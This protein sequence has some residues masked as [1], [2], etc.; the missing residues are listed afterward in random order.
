MPLFTTPDGRYTVAWQTEGEGDGNSV[1]YDRGRNLEHPW[2]GVPVWDRFSYEASLGE[3]QTPPGPP[4][5]PPPP[6]DLPPPPPTA[7]GGF[8]EPIASAAARPRLSRA[9]MGFI[10]ERGPFMFPAPYNTRG[11]RI[12][13]VSDGT[14]RPVG[15][16]YW[17]N[18]N[19]HAARAELL[20]F[21][22]CDDVLTIFAVD[23][24]SG[25]VEKR[26]TLP[27]QMT[28]ES[29]YFSLT[30]ADVLYT[31]PSNG[32]PF[33]RYHLTTHRQD[34]IA[35]HVKQ[36]HSSADGRVHSFSID[37]GPAYWRDG[38]IK[39]LPLKGEYDE[40]QIDKSGR[41]LLSKESF[42]RDGRTHQDNCIWDLATGRM[43]ILRDEDGALGH[44][45]MGYG[46]MIGEEDQSDPGGVFRVW[47][48]GDDGTVSDG[49]MVYNVGGWA[50]MT[51][52]VS[53][54]NAKPGAPDFQRALFSSAID[55]DLARAN[56]IVV[57]SLSV[58]D[59]CRVVAPNLTDLHSPGG[60]EEYWRKTRA[61]IDPTGSWYCFSAN[62]AG[63]RMDVF[64]GQI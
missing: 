31:C 24:S 62:M 4:P 57:A 19:N 12:T 5:P 61:N 48:F 32:G 25:R 10:P 60:G 47:Q 22:A 37:N 56:E 54:C 13:N 7:G 46:Y 33:I 40:C 53:H 3:P 8:V 26:E 35:E 42:L 43:S 58:S 41:W 6:P 52:Y 44:S 30:D 1:I 55:Q 28:G 59:F 21:A 23:K 18:I 39:R 16:A 15:M 34:L 29:C 63:D 27:F 64:L 17:P 14:V 11:I 45:D 49:R 9:D 51:R 2:P 50:G 38:L 20:V 36:P